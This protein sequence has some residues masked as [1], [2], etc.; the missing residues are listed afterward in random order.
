MFYTPLAI[1]GASHVK[2]K[3]ILASKLHLQANNRHLEVLRE[4][5]AIGRFG[6]LQNIYGVF[7]AYSK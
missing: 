3:H 4:S 7:C 5:Q 6:T 2:G 1:K